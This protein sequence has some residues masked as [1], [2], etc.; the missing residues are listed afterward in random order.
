MTN[1]QNV[2]YRMLYYT[3][4][5]Y[6]GFKNKVREDSEIW[7]KSEYEV[8]CKKLYLQINRSSIDLRVTKLCPNMYGYLL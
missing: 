7:A 6:D 5:N 8:R 3:L 4:S 2:N 1:N